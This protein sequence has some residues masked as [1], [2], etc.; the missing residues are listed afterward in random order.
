MVRLGRQHCHPAGIRCRL[1]TPEKPP[2]PRETFP[3]AVDW[4]LRYYETRS[5][6]PHYEILTPFGAYAAA[7]MNAEHRSDYNIH[8]LL[9]WVFDR[10]SARPTKNMISGEPW[11]GKDVR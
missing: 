8:K 9:N 10:S 11:G 2:T 4:A 6:N 3:E 7:R 5:S 1:T